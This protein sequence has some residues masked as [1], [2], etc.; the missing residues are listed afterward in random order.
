MTKNWDLPDQLVWH[1]TGPHG[2][3]LCGPYPRGARI[4]TI[5]DNQFPA[6]IPSEMCCEHCVEAAATRPTKVT[7]TA[8][9]C[10]V[11]AQ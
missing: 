5:H 9:A 7:G 2:A 10:R 1:L 4:A 6:D 11:E 3:P 8:N